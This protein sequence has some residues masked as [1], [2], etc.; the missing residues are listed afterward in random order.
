MQQKAPFIV[1][2]GP[3]GSGTTKHTSWLTERLLA[4]GKTVTQ[5]HEPTDGPIGSAIREELRSGADIDPLNVQQRF[6]DDRKWHA[7][8]LITPSITEGTWV[9]TDRYYHSTIT[10]GMAQGLPREE[11]E[12]MNSEA[13]EPD[14]TFFLLPPLWVCR[15]R[16]ERREA[17]DSFELEDFQRRVYA[18]YEKLA[19]ENSDIV[20][21]DTSGEKDE[22]AEKIYQHA[23]ALQKAPATV[24]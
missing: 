17:T 11:L 5:T 21:I 10:Y 6:S 2:E 12:A 19:A 1:L 14:L 23:I 13:P 20:V 9:I 24:S 16:L 4:E 15:E 18:M 3:D 7:D 22:V 8:T